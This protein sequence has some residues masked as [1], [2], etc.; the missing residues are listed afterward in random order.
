MIE[1]IISITSFIFFLVSH[2]MISSK[3]INHIKNPIFIFVLSIV[4]FSIICL[5]SSLYYQNMVKNYFIYSTSFYYAFVMIYMNLHAGIY[6]SVS[7]R[8]LHELFL[9][10]NKTMSLIELNEKYPQNDLIYNRLKLM[11]EKK[12]LIKINNSY[13]CQNKAIILVKIN[14]FFKKL[15]KLSE[16]G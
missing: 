4:I 13:S 16:T 1:I 12:W 15:Y 14:L 10:K 5:I 3:N 6:K 7:I 9:S 2:V 8:I 11:V